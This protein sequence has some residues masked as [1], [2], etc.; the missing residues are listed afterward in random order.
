MIGKP[1]VFHAKILMFGEY[2][3]ICDSMGL[4][5]P[6]AH[7]TG[8]LGFISDEQYTEY[9]FAV[10][11]NLQLHE[12]VQHLAGLQEQG[13]LPARIDLEQLRKDVG[14][15][16]YFESNIPQ[17]YGIGSSGALVAALYYHYSTDPVRRK[18]VLTSAD[19][20]RLKMIFS[21]ME[22]FFHGVSS[23]LDPLLCY[24]RF[25]LLIRNRNTIETVSVP[26]DKIGKD[27]AIFLIDTGRPGNTGPLVSL[28]FEWCNDE[29]FM[30]AVKD[31]LIPANNGCITTLLSGD[32]MEFHRHL[33]QLSRFQYRYFKEMIPGGFEAVW[34]ASLEQDDFRLK[35]CGSGGGGFLLG[36]ASNYTA[37]QEFFRQHR[38]TP[39]LVHK[40]S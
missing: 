32:M 4:T 22:T 26:R 7:F 39:I 12:Y 34:E 23:G 10:K 1:E 14:K 11:S 28:F 6:Y 15:G 29:A 40:N 37:A 27:G 30:Q 16:L 17:G 35:L 33:D 36:I 2:S 21:A 13:D 3:V 24:I 18:K 38:L 19:I 5:I 31:V 9:E 20:T 8:E 25:P